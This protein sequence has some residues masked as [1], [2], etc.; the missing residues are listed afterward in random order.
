MVG[1]W[2]WDLVNVRGGPSI[3][4]LPAPPRGPS[5]AKDEVVLSKRQFWQFHWIINLKLDI[6]LP[7]TCRYIR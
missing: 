6:E 4:F 5:V 3:C 7:Y 1:G 2:V